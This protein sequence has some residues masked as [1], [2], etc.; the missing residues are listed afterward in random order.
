MRDAVGNKITEKSLLCWHLDVEQLKH[1]G[2]IVYAVSV[3]DGGI[4]MG[5]SRELTPATLLVQ[6]PIMVTRERGEEPTVSDILCVVNPQA[7]AAL[8]SLMGSVKRDGRTQ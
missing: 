4:S 3:S 7:E 5:D 1:R 8:E 6:V 2:L